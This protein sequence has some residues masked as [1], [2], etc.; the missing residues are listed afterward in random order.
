MLS[1]RHP[2]RLVRSRLEGVQKAIAGGQNAYDALRRAGFVARYD[3]AVLEAAERNV[4][5]AWG[6]EAVAASIE[7]RRRTR[8][9]YWAGMLFPSLLLLLG[10][11]A[12]FIIVAMMLP[13]FEIIKGLA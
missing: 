4:H 10:A 7:R 3:A 12:G 2:L 6:L 9:H 11:V 1:D 5:L 13:L 8:L